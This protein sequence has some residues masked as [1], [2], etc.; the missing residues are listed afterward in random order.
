M[1]TSK[2]SRAHKRTGFWHKTGKWSRKCVGGL[3]RGLKFVVLFPLDFVY[4]FIDLI[5]VNFYKLKFVRSRLKRSCQASG[6]ARGG[7]VCV[8]S[9]KYRI[10]WML[11]LVC[12]D[13]SPGVRGTEGYCACLAK[14]GRL[15]RYALRSS[16]ALVVLVALYATGF[17][18][19][20]RVARHYQHRGPRAITTRDRQRAA[21]GVK[22]ARAAMTRGEWAEAG[23]ILRNALDRDPRSVPAL[24]ALS[25]CLQQDGQKDDAPQC[26]MRVAKLQ[27]RNA[28]VL[29]RC[30]MLLLESRRGNLA[31]DY[32]TKALA[33]A[34]ASSDANLV[35]A[36]LFA[37]SNDLKAARAHLAKVK[38]AAPGRSHLVDFVRG[39]LALADGNIAESESLLRQAAA[40]ETPW[41][42]A[43]AKYDLADVFF[44]SQ[45][46]D[47]AEQTLKSIEAQGDSLGV[48]LKLA[49]LLLLQGKKDEALK[50]CRQ[51]VETQNNEELG[52]A[53]V[54]ELLLAAGLT[55][56]ALEVASTG[57]RTFPKSVRLH[58]VVAEVYRRAGLYSSAELH[59]RNAL[60]IDDQNVAAGLIL[61]GTLNAKAQPQPA[62][63][64][65]DK[66]AAANPDRLDVHRLRADAYLRAGK[67]DEA[68]EATKAAA[69]ARPK[70][71]GLQE[72]LGEMLVRAG[73]PDEARKAFT[74]VT[75]LA[76][77]RYSAFVQLALV[78]QKQGDHPAA[79]AHYRAGL[80]AS[81]PLRVVALNNL[82]FLMLTD[83]VKPAEALGLAR[84]AA[85][86]A[87]TSSHV[88]DTLAWAL[89]ANGFVPEARVLIR[90]VVSFQPNQASYLYRA[91]LISYRY[92]DMQGALAYL[93]RAAAAGKD[94]AYVSRI[95]AL[96]TEV[97]RN[98]AARAD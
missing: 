69:G 24:L 80:A 97:E 82:A 6:G 28:A 50:L 63:E 1:T 36:V 12:A 47:E 70:S 34:P 77:T 33:V 98:Q 95:K 64:L 14:R 22:E 61:A 52:R 89:L 71:A 92:G 62:L 20:Y 79:R 49:R 8:P 57:L 81:G 11:R 91:A 43:L 84:M 68:L 65:L 37:S 39:K 51:I 4:L 93:G 32:A 46:T 85:Q 15:Q 42:A 66:L 35:M 16:V 30:A 53:S 23:I 55:D 75:T 78:E 67:Q 18:G 38:K 25:E 9:R 60:A 88:L 87:P 40:S 44:M 41:L 19:V 27:P 94:T 21:D 59:C 45:R 76:P 10:P 2:R 54:S 58:L 29:E 31:R 3:W 74:A 7:C 83:D 96:K 56:A 26:L 48:R 86:L 72:L 13:V 90:Q 73:K 5:R 17:Y